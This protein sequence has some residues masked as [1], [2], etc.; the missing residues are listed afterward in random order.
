MSQ[1]KQKLYQILKLFKFTLDFD[2]AIVAK[3]QTTIDITAKTF[4]DIHKV[5]KKSKPNSTDYI[6]HIRGI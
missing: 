1:R 6:I 2:L 4:Q 5:L 3:T